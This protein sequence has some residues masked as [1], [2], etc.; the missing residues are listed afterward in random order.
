MIQSSTSDIMQKLSRHMGWLHKALRAQSAGQAFPDM[1]QSTLSHL[2]LHERE[3]TISRF[4]RAYSQSAE[5]LIN[6]NDDFVQKMTGALDLEESDDTASGANRQDIS[7]ATAENIIADRQGGYQ[8]ASMMMENLGRELKRLD[9]GN[10][11][12]CLVNLALDRY[13]GGDAEYVAELVGQHLVSTLRGFDDVYRMGKG[14]FFLAMKDIDILDAVTVLKRIVRQIDE[15]K[16]G[17]AAD[18]DFTVS[19][20]VSMPEPGGDLA[21]AVEILRTTR[22][23]AQDDGGNRVYEHSE[24]SPLARM[25]E[26]A[27]PKSQD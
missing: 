26:Q 22:K 15:M 5:A 27:T 10:S 8:D 21:E 9:H 23:D 16:T 7:D 6:T 4:E 13:E 19:A 12:M 17:D 24:K 20:A 3:K 25:M 11:Q 18:D 1:P 2:P 14:E